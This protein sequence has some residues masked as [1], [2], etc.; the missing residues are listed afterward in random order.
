M[1]SLNRPNS[2]TLWNALTETNTGIDVR[3][4]NGSD[5]VNLSVTDDGQEDV[6]VTCAMTVE[7]AL[8]LI[9]DLVTAVEVAMSN[10][11]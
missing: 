5:K 3:V 1:S 10:R 11:R 8:S 4:D 7:N 2:V 6:I 9:S